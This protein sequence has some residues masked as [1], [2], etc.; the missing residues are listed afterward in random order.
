[1]SAVTWTG[2][3]RFLLKPTIIAGTAI[4]TLSALFASTPAYSA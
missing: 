3:F 1:M 2:Q 4:V